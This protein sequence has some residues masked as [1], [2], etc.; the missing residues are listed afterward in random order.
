M[1][2]EN[3]DHR[4]LCL[5]DLFRGGPSAT[6][7]GQTP[8]LPKPVRPLPTPIRQNHPPTEG[9]NLTRVNPFSLR[10]DL[11]G[12]K[13]KLLD[14]PASPVAPLPLVPPA[15]TALHPAAPGDPPR[16]PWAQPGTP[17][18]AALTTVIPRLPRRMEQHCRVL[19]L[20]LWAPQPKSRWSVRAAALS[21]NPQDQPAAARWPVAVAT[22]NF[23]ST[24]S[25]ASQPWSPRSG[26]PP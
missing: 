22:D 2:A 15:A 6:S 12:G 19:A 20:L 5:Q 10:E 3:S 1:S 16:R 21:R 7:P 14:R 17:C 18:H 9:D 8:A 13:I 4:L 11:R 24:C 26:P 25:S 23:I